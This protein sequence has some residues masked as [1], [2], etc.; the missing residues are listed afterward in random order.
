MRIK[1][2]LI[3]DFM[4]KFNIRKHALCRLCNVTRRHLINVL[5]N[6][7]EATCYTLF[8]VA[9]YMGISMLDLIES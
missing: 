2:E 6:N 5:E 8:Q 3:L 4:N 1:S 9:K 7:K